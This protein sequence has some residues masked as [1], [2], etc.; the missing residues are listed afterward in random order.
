MPLRAVTI[1]DTY[2]ELNRGGRVFRFDY[3]SL[4]GGNNARKAEAARQALQNWIDDRILLTGLPPDDPARIAN[5]NLPY[6]FWGTAD[7]V[8]SPTGPYLIGREVVVESVAW[9]GQRVNLTIRRA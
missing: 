7:G 8:P 2:V 3:T 5:P 1:T 9:D 4:P 6:W